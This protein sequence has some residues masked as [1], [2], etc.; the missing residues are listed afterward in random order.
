MGL[1]ALWA[2][3]FGDAG[4]RGMGLVMG[5]SGRGGISFLFG[6]LVNKRKRKGEDQRERFLIR[7][8]CWCGIFVRV[9]FWSEELN[10]FGFRG[11]FCWNSRREIRES[12]VSCTMIKPL[13]GRIGIRWEK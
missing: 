7:L 5:L 4:V 10:T 6:T 12:R 13:Y 11:S 1:A 2:G 3:D 9:T 8:F